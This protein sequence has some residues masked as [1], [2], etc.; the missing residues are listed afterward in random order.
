M[1]AAENLQREDLS[2]IET[3]E[4]IVEIVDAELIKDKEYASMGK[5]PAER[6]KTLLGKLHSI[7]CRRRRGSKVSE[8][9]ELLYNTFV[10]QV[11][12]NFRNL[13]KSLEWQSFYVHDIPL[14]LDICE[15]VR[16]EAIRRGLNR[17]QTRALQ[18]LNE[19]SS[20][21][22]QR[23]T[24]NGHEASGSVGGAKNKD[25]S[26]IDLND[27]SGREINCIAEK[28]A[29]KEGL[30]ELNRHRV[31]PSLKS[32]PV[33]VTMNSLGIP[34][35]RIS[36]LVKINRKTVKKHAENPQ[37]IL[38]TNSDTSRPTA[39]PRRNLF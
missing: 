31:S 34:E 21:E 29:K 28:A 33:I 9:A 22:Y 2:A 32:E 39:T 37:R 8:E 3:I 1:S 6:V 36:A 12:E 26:Q 13:P 18:K 20:E 15:E 24:G 27:L 19:A 17:S 16:E 23:V 30:T 4:T 25:S 35:E 5:K 7:I 14:A 38:S 10:I 11:E